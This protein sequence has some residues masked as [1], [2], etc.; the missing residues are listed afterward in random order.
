MSGNYNLNSGYGAAVAH[1]M[2]QKAQGAKVFM[3]AATAAA[4]RQVWQ[5]LFPVD[6]DGINRYGITIDA[7][8]GYTTA[9][10]GDVILVAPGHTESITAAAGIALDV[11]GVSVIGLGVGNNRPVIT[12]ASTDN[13]GTMTMSG[14]NTRLENIVIV[15][16][17]DALTNALVVTGDNC[18]IDIEHQDTSSA[19]EAATVVRLDTANNCYLKLKH[20]GFIA[21]NAGVSCVRLDGCS[22]VRIDIDQYGIY[23][24]AIVEFVDVLS[25]NVVVNGNFYVSGTTDLSKNV[26][27][28]ITGSIW[29][30]KGFD[31]AAGMTFEGGSGNAVAAGDLSAIASNV[32]TIK[33]DVGG[34]DSATNVLGADD[35]DNQFAST[36][37][38]SNRDGSI[39]E[40]LEAVYAA[41][42]DDVAAN[43]IG[44]DDANN[45]GSTSSVVANV[46]GTI[47]E[48]LEAL[49]DP[50]GGYDP[51]LGF[52]VT[53]T[54][55][56]ADGAG[57]DNLFTVTGRCLITHLSGEVTTVIGGAATLKI[58][59]QTNTVDLCAATTIDTDAVGTMYHL[60]GVK[61]AVLNSGI[62][63]VV[64]STS[65]ANGG[66]QPIIVGDAQAAITL[67]QVLDAA[68]TGNIDWVLY[69]KPLVASA[70][71]VAAA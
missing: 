9:S 44:F 35:A 55:D 16:N 23:S 5:D 53:K 71:V 42:V 24:T 38:T 11:A 37:V 30:V 48:R 51:V 64:G 36:N 52:R 56:L 66:Y 31:S 32:T 33:G 58:S 3:V 19:V 65:L 50:L 6:P 7:V 8:I 46:D 26:V 25:T 34:V 1:A 57:V 59:D 67:A 62:A 4:G 60:D 49:M 22:N 47:V 15:T 40:R 28:T 21:G 43:L 10:R 63:P 2:T 45:V 18:Y 14:N 41:Q 68:D 20:L 61:A 12:I 69:Y 29:S 13:A 17:D 27:D 54:S 39:L 70:N